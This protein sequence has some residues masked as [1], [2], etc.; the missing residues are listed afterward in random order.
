VGK[1]GTSKKG[2]V[3]VKLFLYPARSFTHCSFLT[4]SI[5]A[6][7]VLVLF[8][9]VVAQDDASITTDDDIISQIQIE[10]DFLS[11]MDNAPQTEAPATTQDMP[12]DNIQSTMKKMPNNDFHSNILSTDKKARVY[13]WGEYRVMGRCLC[14]DNSL[15]GDC[16]VVQSTNRTPRKRL[17]QLA[18]GKIKGDLNDT[19][20]YF[21][22]LTER[23]S[24]RPVIDLMIE[25]RYPELRDVYAVV[26]YTIK[27]E[28]I[29]K[30][31]LSDCELRYYDRFDRLQS[32][33]KA[34]C[35]WP[36]DRIIFEMN[37]PFLTNRILLIAK[38]GK[39]K[40]TEVEVYGK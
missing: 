6:F 23:D 11:D 3:T 26:V 12:V 40:I 18:D 35:K 4:G 1:L 14:C 25:V 31:Y 13:G 24:D 34:E 29:E 15:D 5:V 8:F 22:D 17:K 39:S 21:G 28:K 27:N 20:T 2:N 7:V 37:K 9:N 16:I 30:S 38:Y 33:R 19:K 10:D 32:V 36:D